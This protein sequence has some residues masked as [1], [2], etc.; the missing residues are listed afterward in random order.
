MTITGVL[1]SIQRH[2]FR[3]TERG[4]ASVELVIVVPALVLTLGLLV[5]GG[6]LWFA[7]ATVAEAAQTSARSASL[8]RSAEQATVDG[9]AAGRASLSTA[10]LTCADASVSIDTAAF[11]VPVGSPA[12]VTSSVVCRVPFGDILLPGMPGSIV[13][14]A[15]GSSALDT[16]RSR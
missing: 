13:I 4:S 12:T 5:G 14:T 10:G 1:T 6:R 11:A 2:A 15:D 3:R 8:A 7:R 16:Y 9:P